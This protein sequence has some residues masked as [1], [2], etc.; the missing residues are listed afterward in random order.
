MER[1]GEKKTVVVFQS[2]IAF[3]IGDFFNEYLRV[4]DHTVA[5]HASLAGMENPGR[6]EMENQFLISD[7]QGVSC[8]VSTLITDYII[9]ELCIDI[10]N[11]PFTFV[12]P[13]G[14]YYQDIRHSI[15]LS[16]ATPYL[17][18]TRIYGAPTFLTY[19]VYAKVASAC[20]LGIIPNQKL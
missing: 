8:I 6:Y 12:A 5:D 7:H 14:A 20:R 13:L 1:F 17:G 2:A 11:F 18:A 4:E 15:S 10:D 16:Y 9:R 3:Q 19:F